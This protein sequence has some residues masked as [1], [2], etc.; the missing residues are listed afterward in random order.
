MEVLSHFGRAFMD[1]LVEERGIEPGRVRAFTLD[2]IRQIDPDLRA[3][4][5]VD[6]DDKELH[7]TLLLGMD[8]I[9]E[10]FPDLLFPILQA[11]W[12]RIDQEEIS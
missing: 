2:R 9:G 11:E 7:A 6:R 12:D 4:L 8:E 5:V 1:L 3:D 10:N